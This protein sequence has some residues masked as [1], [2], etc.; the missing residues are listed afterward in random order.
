[1]T[2]DFL[3]VIVELVNAVSITLLRRGSSLLSDVG[4]QGRREEEG[5]LVRELHRA[6]I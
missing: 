4:E 3:I 5:V 6:I 1:V 2:A